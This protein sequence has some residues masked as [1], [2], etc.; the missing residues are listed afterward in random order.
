MS[1]GLR[2]SVKLA[3]SNENSGTKKRNYS[4]PA[5][6]SDAARAEAVR[7]R[8]SE[9]EVFIRARAQIVAGRRAY[10]LDGEVGGRISTLCQRGAGRAFLRCGWTSLR[11][12]L[13]GRYRGD[14]GALAFVHCESYRA[15]VAAWNHLDAAQR[16]RNFCWRRTAKALR[17]S[18]LAVCAD[19]DRCEPVFDSTGPTYNRTS[20]NPGFQLV[21]SRIGGRELHHTP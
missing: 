7:G 4:H 1:S 8:Q 17:T 2:L 5:G 13:P 11:R 3:I 18:M 20:K 10:E 15:A 9:V 19:R 6:F 14:D 21:L 16:R 12:L